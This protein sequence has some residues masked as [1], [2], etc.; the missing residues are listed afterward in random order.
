MKTLLPLES[1]IR[2]LGKRWGGVDVDSVI[3]QVSDESE[4][5]RAEQLAFWNCPAKG[6]SIALND[7]LYVLS[8]ATEFFKDGPL[9][10]VGIHFYS[11]GYEGYHA[12]EGELPGGVR[13]GDSKEAVRNKLGV[14]SKN[15]GGNKA[16]GRVWPYWDRYDFPDYSV[17]VQY[18]SKSRV[19]MVTLIWEEHHTVKSNP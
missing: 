2:L 5:N 7:E 4:I 14:S 13:F 6:V 18:D 10:I 17:R 15:G 3:S 9:L 8:K 19:D 12:Y 1:Y 16:V 11:E